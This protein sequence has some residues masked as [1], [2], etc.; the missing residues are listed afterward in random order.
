MK[1]TR[2]VPA[3]WTAAALVAC[4][5]GALAQETPG[6][7]PAGAGDTGSAKAS[8]AA[9]VP[10]AAVEI[11][12]SALLPCTVS[13]QIWNGLLTVDALVGKTGIQRFVL[14]PGM[15]ACTLT[16]RASHLVA[17]ASATDQT[18]VTVLDQAHTVPQAEIP[19][20]QFNTMK[21]ERVPVGMIDVL[22]L[23]SPASARR[24]DA[25]AGWLG[26]S[27][28]SAFQVT[29]A[30]DERYLMLERPSAPLPKTKGVISVPFVMQDGHMVIKL[31]VPGARP[32]TAIFSTSTPVTMIPTSVAQQAKLKALEMLPITQPGTK[33]GKVGRV[34]LP[35]LHVG[36]AILEQ[37]NAVYVAPDAPPELNRN[38][39]II[40]TD[41]L[42][43]YKVTISYK[44]HLMVLTPPGLP[45]ADK[46]ATDDDADSPKPQ[47]TRPKPQN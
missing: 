40:G 42:R 23:L 5:Y 27:L 4:C 1:T 45:D 25:P 35:E 11:P 20:L 41:L 44:R 10:T 36:R 21:L 6:N 18:H 32:F 19:Q 2:S 43:R 8:K 39:A 29:L 30:F 26:A 3:I 37:V 24:F 9:A 15:D 16:P 17:V 34:V 22:A 46:K 38:L 12:K 13:F 14:D 33:T 28:L 31:A 7:T 47:R